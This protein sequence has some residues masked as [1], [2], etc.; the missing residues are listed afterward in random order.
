MIR[1]IIFDFNGVLVDD[2][3]L[4]FELFRDVVADLGVALTER[5]YHEIY[6][7]YD[8]RRCFEE[9]LS[10]AGQPLSESRLTEL[11]G[12]K[13]DLYQERASEGV[14]IFPGAAECLVAMAD[15]WPVAINSGALLAEIELALKTMDVRDRVA[16][17]IAAEDTTECKPDP[18]GYE[19]ALDA[20]RSTHGMDLEAGHCLVI[21]DSLAGVQSA[22]GAGMWVVGVSNTYTDRE[23]RTAG[24]DA[25]VASLEGFRPETVRRLFL[26]EVTP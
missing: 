16:A 25:V 8:D 24:A 9:L 17:I 7:G 14:R 12:R 5:Q 4:H 22:K 21:E 13:A 10:D 15:R 20:L 2:E 18:E 23:L 3:H 26:P 1:A 19:L 11:V 6:L